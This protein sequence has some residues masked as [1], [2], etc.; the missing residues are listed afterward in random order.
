M[1]GSDISFQIIMEDG[2]YSQLDEVIEANFEDECQL[3]GK[4]VD[5]GSKNEGICN[6]TTELEVSKKIK[7]VLTDSGMKVKCLRVKRGRPNV[8]AESMEGG[9]RSLIM[10]AHMDTA[11]L[12]QDG[13]E[14]SV[15]RNGN[16]YG[17]GVWDMKASI[18]AYLFALKAIRTT[19]IRLRGKL[20]MAFVVDGKNER[21]SKIGLSYLIRKGIPGKAAILAKPGTERIAIGH[22]GGYRFKVKTYGEAVKT[23]GLTWEKKARGRNA[24]A[25]MAKIIVA[26][27][28]LELP[29]KPAKGFPQRKPVVTFPVKIMGGSSAEL[30]PDVCEAWGDVRLMPGNTDKQV[31]LLITEKL[32]K[33]KLGTWEIEDI[34]FVPSMEIEK[35]EPVVQALYKSS[36]EVIGRKPKIEGCGMWNDAWMLSARGV[37][38]IAGFG[39]DGGVDINRDGVGEWVNL[40]SLKQITKIYARTIVGYLGAEIKN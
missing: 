38:C 19:N 7:E 23:G 39:P 29:Y 40:D 35:H 5:T 3:L 25:D 28:N 17:P 31:K 32:D 8:V 22:R 26:L 30:V 15:I 6:C 11:P 1:G 37:P 14:K 21:P 2:L 16:I 33:L 24:I 9:R 20:V 13:S 18:A 10:L 12:V 36:L 34:L 27:D 4:L